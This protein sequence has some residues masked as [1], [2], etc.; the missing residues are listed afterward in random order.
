MFP[1]VEG[2][3]SL[4]RCATA[5]A[6]CRIK[7]I[8]DWTADQLDSYSQTYNIYSAV[9]VIGHSTISDFAW[10]G[11][12]WCANKESRYNVTDSLPLAS[13][14]SRRL[15]PSVTSLAFAE[16]LLAVL[17]QAAAGLAM[18]PCLCLAISTLREQRTQVFIATTF[19]C[20]NNISCRPARKFTHMCSLIFWLRYDMLSILL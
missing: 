6:R 13:P 20:N 19:V 10:Y 18:A 15:C 9:F 8:Y 7:G 1:S 11:Y 12:L 14:K 2:R 3:H 17:L 5:W 4:V 16:N